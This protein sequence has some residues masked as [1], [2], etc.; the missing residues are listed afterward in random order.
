MRFK[1]VSLK[2]ASWMLGG[3]AVVVA[4]GGGEQCDDPGG[5]CLQHATS[6]GSSGSAG[7]NSTGGKAQSSGGQAGQSVGGDTG[8]GGEPASS[9]GADNGGDTSISFGGDFGSGGTITSGGSGGT[10]ATGGYGNVGAGGK[11]GYGGSISTGGGPTCPYPFSPSECADQGGVGGGGAAAVGG[12]SA[13]G[14]AGAGD[15]AWCQGLPVGGTGGTGGTGDLLLDDFE[16]G[17]AYT[18]PFPDGRGWW[19]A[20]ND[21]TSGGVMYPEICALVDGAAKPTY[22]PGEHDL[23]EWSLRAYGCGFGPYIAPEGWGPALQVVLRRGPPDCTLPFDASG[24]R[25]IKFLAR[26]SGIMTVFVDTAATTPVEYGGTCSEG[27]YNSYVVDLPF[28]ADWSLID[29]P[30]ASLRQLWEPGEY[31]TD[32]Q[33][34]T[35]IGWRST[36]ATFEFVI[37][38]VTFYK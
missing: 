23:S 6:A 37:D 32:P 8:R 4:C 27:C 31:L 25:G 35:S 9:G 12:A 3:V 34:I 36:A 19:R 15:T 7:S 10:A 22:L 30:F 26:G 2:W 11:A 16:D 21:G 13:A 20:I 14:A 38:D 28:D 5:L 24:Y 18:L 33:G 17:D 1:R 29:V